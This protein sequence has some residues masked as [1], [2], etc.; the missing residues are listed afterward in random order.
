VNLETELRDGLHSAA[1]RVGS[2]GDDAAAAD[3]VIARRRSERRH[4]AAALAVAV[5]VLLVTLAIPLVASRSTHEGTPAHPGDSTPTVTPSGQAARWTAPVRGS[6]ADDHAFLEA[7]RIREWPAS[8]GPQPAVPTRSVVFA[9][10]V[11]GTRWVIVAGL[12]EGRLSGEFFTGPA[13][14]TA[15]ALTADAFASDLQPG[16]EIGHVLADAKGGTLFVLVTPGD[17]V[18][19]SPGVAVDAAGRPSRSYSPVAAENGVVVTRVAGAFAGTSLDY[20]VLRNGIVVGHGPSS[21]EFASIDGMG[22]AAGQLPRR[23]SRGA[24]TPGA[25]TMAL[26]EVLQATGFAPA[27]VHPVLLWTGPVPVPAGGSIQAVMVAVT[28]PSGAVLVS[29]A[30]SEGYGTVPGGPCGTMAYPAGTSLGALV[31]V[32]RC[33]LA[34][35]TVSHPVLLVSAPPID[36]R[37]VLRDSAGSVAADQPLVHGFGVVT[38]PGAVAI[39]TVS[40]PH[41]RPV[42]VKPVDANHDA[43]VV[44]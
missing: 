10:D 3:A 35:G 4:R 15:D 2:G 34:Q 36:D 24:A 1:W 32:A 40:G 42:Q 7:V 14:A 6:L 41:S 23:P 20:Q 30:I 44:P 33:D 26:Q 28:M 29:T 12:V 38:D 9:G 13:G 18:E 21:T 17:Q 19:V 43:L 11:H 27:D 37:V 25:V 39:A 16:R 22:D 5:C 8:P 31:V